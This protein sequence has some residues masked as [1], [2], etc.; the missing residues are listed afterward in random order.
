MAAPFLDWKRFQDKTAPV[1]EHIIPGQTK[2]EK[3]GETQK[4]EEIDKKKFNQ[5]IKL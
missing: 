5:F 4:L 3:N 2:F 1:V